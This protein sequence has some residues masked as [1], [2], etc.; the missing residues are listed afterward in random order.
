MSAG[1]WL[2]RLGKVRGEGAYLAP[3]PS[4]PGYMQ[5]LSL[6]QRD[7]LRIT[8]LDWA[9]DYA[10]S[11]GGPRRAAARACAMSED[12]RLALHRWLSACRDVAACQA[13]PEAVRRERER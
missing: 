13:P 7:A 11:L 2:V 6:R 5:C 4:S 8:Q 1:P 9:M 12:L 10:W 3:S